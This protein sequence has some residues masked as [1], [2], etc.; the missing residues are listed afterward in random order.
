MLIRFVISI[1]IGLVGAYIGMEVCQTAFS[2]WWLGAIT[3]LS[4]FIVMN[5]I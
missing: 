5:E 4:I 2:S 3:S 1:I